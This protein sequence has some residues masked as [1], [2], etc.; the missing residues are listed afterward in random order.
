MTTNP[1]QKISSLSPRLY[2]LLLAIYPADFRREYGREMQQ[3][4]CDLCRDELR[5]NGKL[6]LLRLWLRTLADLIRTASGEHSINVRARN[7]FVWSVLGGGLALRAFSPSLIASEWVVKHIL[8]VSDLLVIIAI[9]WRLLIYVRAMPQARY[10]APDEGMTILCDQAGGQK[11]ASLL[12]DR[13]HH[14]IPLY[15]EHGRT[16]VERLLKDDER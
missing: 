16:P 13:R 7:L 12:A 1:S 9:L 4:F 5:R 6:G 8:H 14:P 11:P 2:R 10:L 15:D 3:V